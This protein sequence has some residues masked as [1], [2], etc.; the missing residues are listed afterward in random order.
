MKEGAINGFITGNACE[1]YDGILGVIC[2]MDVGVRVL[3]FVHFWGKNG[4]T[5]FLSFSAV[6]PFNFLILRGS[7]EL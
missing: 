1:F 3:G 7:K 4:S 2:E 5:G 6:S